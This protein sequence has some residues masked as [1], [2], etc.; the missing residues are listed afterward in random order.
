[1][2]WSWSVFL[3]YY[4][5]LS[6]FFIRINVLH[7]WE[8]FAKEKKNNYCYLFT[9]I[10]KHSTTKSDISDQ[11]IKKCVNKQSYFAIFYS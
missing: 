7:E 8:T 3:W 1:M 4:Q 6:N 10:I 5:M 11:M 9:E 2:I